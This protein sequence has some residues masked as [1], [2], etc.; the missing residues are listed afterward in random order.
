MDA[1]MQAHLLRVLQDGT[2]RPLGGSEEIS[3]D[4]R[5]LSASN[6]DLEKEMREGRFRE[7][8]FYRLNVVRIDIPPLTGRKED[9]PLLV[10]YFSDHHA[11]KEKPTF[12]EN[13]I[14]R[15]I[16]SDWPGN[17]RELENEVLRALTMATPG[18]PIAEKDLSPRLRGA[19]GSHTRPEGGSLK[20]RMDSFERAIIQKVLG[21]CDG[22]ASRAADKL[23]ISRAG[24][25]KKL[26]RHGIRK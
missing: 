13:A 7:D 6:R 24:L 5:I 4:V 20:Q 9:I 18:K 19:N 2:F 17:V 25:Y 12:S 8:L 26:D 15:L 23:G 3:V 22:N 14:D 10:D 11:V 1:S 21:E 16:S